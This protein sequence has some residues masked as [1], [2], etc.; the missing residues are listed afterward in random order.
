MVVVHPLGCGLGRVSGTRDMDAHTLQALI[1]LCLLSLQTTSKSSHK[2]SQQGDRGR[3]E[4]WRCQDL[5]YRQ[6]ATYWL[7]WSLSPRGGECTRRAQW[8]SLGQ[9]PQAPQYP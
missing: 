5:P 9:S 2:R 4:I 1:I 3:N 7:H 6:D 8:R